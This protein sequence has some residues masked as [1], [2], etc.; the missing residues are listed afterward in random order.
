MNSYLPATTAASVAPGRGEASCSWGDQQVLRSITEWRSCPTVGHVFQQLSQ[1]TGK[2][3]FPPRGAME[4]G[5]PAGQVTGR[6]P[7]VLLP[8]HHGTHIL[9][10]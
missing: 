2:S 1:G 9:G 6:S 4:K 8:G 10:T 5:V 7:S 3:N